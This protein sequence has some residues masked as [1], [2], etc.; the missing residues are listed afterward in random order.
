L[1]SAGSIRC[2]VVLFGSIFGEPHATQQHGENSCGD[3]H[4]AENPKEVML[5]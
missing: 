2:S 4:R 5:S 1:Q 3:N